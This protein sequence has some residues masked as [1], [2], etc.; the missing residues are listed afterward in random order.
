[1][2]VEQLH[3]HGYTEVETDISKDE[4]QIVMDGY[5][6]FTKLPAD[7]QN[8]TNYFLSDRGDG[9]FG[10]FKRVPGAETFRGKASDNKD[11][12]H[13]GASTRQIVEASLPAG[14][15][16]EMASFLN[17]AESLFWQAQAAK[18]QALGSLG[19]FGLV[20]LNTGSL[21]PYQNVFL[22][23]KAPCNDVLR[24]INYYDSGSLLAKPHLDRSAVTLA[25]GES[26][27][28]LRMTPCSIDTPVEERNANLKEVVHNPGVAKFFLGAGWKNL[29]HISQRANDLPLG[30]H[31]VVQTSEVVD[32]YVRRWSVILFSTPHLDWQDYKVPGRSL[33]RP[34]QLS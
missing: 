2:S 30:W 8:S 14:L 5:N 1:M 21:V 34:Q 24:L 11:I 15:P 28:G 32:D 27:P 7:I 33:T 20:D 17:D 23:K 9:D 12:F 13:F 22:D 19:L 4:L 16:P 31:D 25:L 29:R 10:S 26:H 6:A 18:S 3:Q